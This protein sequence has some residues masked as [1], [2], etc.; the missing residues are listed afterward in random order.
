MKNQKLRNVLQGGNLCKDL[1]LFTEFI[2]F[3]ETGRSTYYCNYEISL[4]ALGDTDEYKCNLP[5]SSTFKTSTLKNA[6]R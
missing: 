4:I 3:T 6:R 1:S 5:P 2:N